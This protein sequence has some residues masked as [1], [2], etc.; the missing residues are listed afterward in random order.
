MYSATDRWK[1]NYWLSE[2]LQT[3]PMIS[4]D[5]LFDSKNKP[6]LMVSKTQDVNHYLQRQS[7]TICPMTVTVL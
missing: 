4:P 3:E 5:V 2:P 1:H 6:I 7:Q